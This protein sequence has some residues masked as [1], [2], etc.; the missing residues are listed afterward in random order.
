MIYSM[1]Q[2]L[3]KEKSNE[4]ILWSFTVFFYF[5]LFIQI[6]KLSNIHIKIYFQ[7]KQCIYI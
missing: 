6:S 5:I 7:H 2:K 4:P 1:K 3:H